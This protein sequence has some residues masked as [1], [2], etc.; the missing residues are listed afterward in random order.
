MLT[1]LSSKASDGCSKGVESEVVVLSL[2]RVH[3][4]SLLSTVKSMIATIVVVVVLLPLMLASFLDASL[5]QQSCAIV[6]DNPSWCDGSLTITPP[7]VADV[8]KKVVVLLGCLSVAVEALSFD[9]TDVRCLCC[10][11]DGDEALDHDEVEVVRLGC[12]TDGVEA[13]NKADV[14][15]V[16]VDCCT[17]GVETLTLDD[18]ADR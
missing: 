16:S 11:T 8:V 18:A 7:T 3:A 1:L 6:F 4:W 5:S 17:G 15:V 2:C 10:A 9:D 14:E 13:L 12:C